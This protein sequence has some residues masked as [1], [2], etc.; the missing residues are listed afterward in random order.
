MATAAEILGVQHTPVDLAANPQATATIPLQ[1]PGQTVD[2]N[3]PNPTAVQTVDAQPGA[4]I[5]PQPMDAY[6]DPEIRMA[7][8]HHNWLDR[9]MN[10][11]TNILAG[12]TS[13]HVT[14]DPQGNVTVTHDPA[15][16]GEKWGRIAAA[17]LGGAAKGMAAGQGPGG[18]ARALATG[19]Q[20]GQD[21]PQQQ[22]TQANAQAANMN[23]Q[24]LAIANTALTHQKLVQTM[25]ASREAGLSLGTQEAALLQQ[26]A[27]AIAAGP[28]TK[29]LGTFTDMPG[30][31]KALGSNPDAMAGLT[32]Q[33]LK[34]IPTADTQG[35]VQLRAFLVDKGAD[36]RKNDKTE[37]ALYIDVDP[38]TQEPL[39][40]SRDINPQSQPLVQI[41]QAQ[42]TTTAQFV[43]MHNKYRLAEST[44]NKK[45]AAP[46]PKSAEE[47][48]GMA[49]V[50]T[51]P[52]LRQK[53]LDAVPDLQ[54]LAVEQK[55]A[56]R[57]PGGGSVPSLG[58]GVGGP[59]ALAALP[60]GDAATVRAIGEGRQ[61]APSR[62]TKEGQ[63]IMGMV[64][65]VYP[66]YDATQFPAYQKMRNYMT[67]GAGGVGL[68]FIGTARNHLAELES[69]IPD[70]VTVP[71]IGSAINWA[72]NTATR[73]T[74][75]QLKAFESARS[76]VSDEVAKAY[77]GGALSEGEHNQMMS[78][79]NESDSPG[80]LR[81]SIGEFRRLL[82]GK[83]SSYQTQ[84][85]SG[86]PRGTVSPNAT[87][88]NLLA[89]TPAAE[90]ITTTAAPAAAPAR[91]PASTAA[92]A[93]GYTPGVNSAQFPINQNAQGHR[94]QWNGKIWAPLP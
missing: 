85:N 48:R 42:Q 80:A 49:A 79:I 83:L 58:G 52:V 50:E 63:R 74:S 43:D 81:G 94:I 40:K 4:T 9:L 29:D 22:L 37:K 86:M 46:F 57:A 18:A 55:E 93:T 77:K 1:D 62:F 17:V 25:L 26:T 90:S 61:S 24:Q 23:A 36:N 54:R 78:L 41:R 35:H 67:S 84:W 44:A 30:I 2:V 82:N 10:T 34:V 56:G 88:E 70:N 21:I 12:D 38:T 72:K 16:G 91:A 89:G 14:R 64:N 32:N 69:T 11:A 71:L 68:N 5:Q 75:P 15:T 53:Y 45:E 39:L 31:M 87:I 66:D 65:Q 33:A 7:A 6:Q 60:P 27:D 8:E 47:A 13:V 20:T 73:A 3:A 19:F 92:P 59:E 76:A 51:D 28:N